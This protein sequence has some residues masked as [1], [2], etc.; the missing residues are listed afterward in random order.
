[1]A[2]SRITWYFSTMNSPRSGKRSGAA[3]IAFD[4][5]K[6]GRELQIDAAFVRNMPGFL[7]DS[8]PHVLV[9]HEIL[10]VTRGRGTLL[11]DGERIAVSPGAIVFCLPG[12]L[13]EWHLAGGLDGACVCFS[14]DFFT[15]VFADVRFLD[16][17]AFF[18]SYRASSAIML[19]CSEQRVFRARFAA[20]RSELVGLREDA[21]HRLRAALYEVLVLVNR[22][23]TKR[24]RFQGALQDHRID[25]FVRL[26]DRDFRVRHR[27]HEYAHELGCTPGYLNH[28]C[29]TQIHCKAGSMLR[30]RIAL[31]ARRLL[32]SSD[33][34]AGQ[35]ARQLGF[36]DAAYFSRFVRRETGCTPSRLR[37][38]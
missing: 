17:F 18:R 5:M 7:T 21:S 32:L 16:Q 1:M 35:I 3:L 33:L 36:D 22:W 31:E 26:I 13:R 24:A 2:E 34:T 4:R 11:L 23:Y 29:R 10:L 12:Q 37:A 14:E 8:S 27:I 6:Y 20:M 15:D 30:R 9:F 38:R 25:R 19:G 28:L